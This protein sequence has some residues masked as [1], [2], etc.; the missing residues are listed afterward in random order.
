MGPCRDPPPL[1]AAPA[2]D[3]RP[4]VAG[5]KKVCARLPRGASSLAV[6]ARLFAHSA[7]CRAGSLPCARPLRRS[8][9]AAAVAGSVR[10]VRPSA[11]RLLAPRLARAS[12]RAPRLWRSA[13]RRAFALPRALAARA[14]LLLALA[15]RRASVGRPC[16]AAGSRCR[17]ARDA[18]SPLGPPLRAS[19]PAA[20]APGRVGP[21]GLLFALRA[22]GLFLLA[23][24]AALR[25]WRLRRTRCLDFITPLRPVKPQ[26]LDW[27]LCGVIFAL[28]S[29][30]RR[31]TIFWQGCAGHRRKML[32]PMVRQNR[33]HFGVGGFFASL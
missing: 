17:S 8:A 15:W 23:R 29:G 20:P 6:S 13:A 19:G 22:P 14:A 16:L 5:T 26:G 9:P 1:R 24:P 31:D 12:A 10:A 25:F 21:S 32:I 18:G 33:L 11:L 27:P 2:T 30:M 7:S 28:T 4:P 3:A